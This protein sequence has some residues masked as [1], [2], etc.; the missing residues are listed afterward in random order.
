MQP[1]GQRHAAPPAGP[2]RLTRRSPRWSSSPLLTA[3]AST[4]LPT[5]ALRLLLR[6]GLLLQ[7]LQ[8]LH[9]ARLLLRLLRFVEGPDPADDRVLHDPERAGRDHVEGEPRGVV[10]E[11]DAE[12]DAEEEEDA[13]DPPQKKKNN[14]TDNSP[15][16]IAGEGPDVRPE[17]N[18]ELPE[19][20]KK[21]P[22]DI[23]SA[24]TIAGESN[25]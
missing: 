5:L 11:E 22:V 25:S 24:E 10:V 20:G 9:P 8:L 12:E 3:P 6:H 21:N 2:H 16:T 14:L 23:N 18:L 17:L 7:V 15:E 1:G 4:G 19:L 13:E